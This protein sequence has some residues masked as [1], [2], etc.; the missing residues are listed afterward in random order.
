M[1]EIIKKLSEDKVNHYSFIASGCGAIPF[2]LL[3]VAATTGVQIKMVQDLCEINGIEY[4]EEMSK[5]L[6]ASIAGNFLKLTGVSFIKSIPFIGTIIGGFASAILSGISTYL[7]GHAFI[8]YVDLNSKNQKIKNLS[9]I[10]LGAFNDIFKKLS[11]DKSTVVKQSMKILSKLK[12]K[13]SKEE[14]QTS[15]A[16]TQG[17]TSR[18]DSDLFKKGIKAFGGNKEEFQ[19]WLST[20]S[21]YL[22]NQ[23][24]FTMILDGREKEVEDMLDSMMATQ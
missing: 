20:P 8:K 5:A 3:D 13:K 4:K 7:L 11:E 12:L 10:D 1:K 22:K 16:K 6:V 2:P 15:T 18:H 23:S 19:K 14:T 9:Q 17:D 24:P 21:V